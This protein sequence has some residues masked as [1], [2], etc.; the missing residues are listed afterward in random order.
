MDTALF[1]G[2]P[3]NAR[4]L[5][6]HGARVDKLTFAAGLGDVERLQSLLERDPEFTDRDG[7][8]HQDSLERA[9]IYA[10]L[11]D[12]PEAAEFLL[13][14]AVDVDVIREE[15]H[16]NPATALH[17][18]AWLGFADIARL[19][20]DRGGPGEPVLGGKRADGDHLRNGR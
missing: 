4:V 16:G 2:Y 9:L 15:I 18:A 7:Y 6:S 11:N 1:F 19:P 3:R 17:F 14:R 13:D 12:R 20:I 10:C 5:A 8:T